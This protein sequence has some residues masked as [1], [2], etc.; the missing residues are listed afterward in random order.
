M[1]WLLFINN[2]LELNIYL[3]ILRFH[4]IFSCCLGAGGYWSS[5]CKGRV[6]PQTSQQ[7]IAAELWE[8]SCYIEMQEYFVCFSRFCLWIPVN[9]TRWFFWSW[10]QSAIPHSE[11][12]VFSALIRCQEC[13]AERTPAIWFSFNM[14]SSD[15]MVFGRQGQTINTGLPLDLDLKMS[16][17]SGTEVY[18]IWTT[19]ATELHYHHIWEQ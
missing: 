19:A 14:R 2:R 6:T 7:S 9:L 18:S 12:R 13:T 11:C 1:G 17:N 16:V 10:N 3:F 5:L 15:F 4:F 8:A